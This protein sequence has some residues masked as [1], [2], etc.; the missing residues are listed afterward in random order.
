MR[1]EVF[2]KREP[3]CHRSET[4]ESYC[5]HSAMLCVQNHRA[6]DNTTEITL[7]VFFFSLSSS[8]HRHTAQDKAVL[9]SLGV[10]HTSWAQRL[11]RLTSTLGL[12]FTPTPAYSTAEWKHPTVETLTSALTSIQQQSSYTMD[13]HK[14]VRM[15]V[16]MFLRVDTRGCIIPESYLFL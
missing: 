13:F 14:T 5:K 3:I 1:N 12:A 16:T 6:T 11:A 10:T 9:L 15:G 8:L 2:H 7:C 4:S